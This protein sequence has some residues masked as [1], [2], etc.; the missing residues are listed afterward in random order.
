M[1]AKTEF[2]NYENIFYQKDRFESRCYTCF[3]HAHFARNCNQNFQ[4][5]RRGYAKRQYTDWKPLQVC[6][7][8]T[9]AENWWYIDSGCS[10][11]MTGDKN[12]CTK[13][14]EKNIGEVSFGDNNK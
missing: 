7:K 1:I 5:L 13:L 8:S 12:L 3:K 2:Q 4:N 11:H 10:R 9:C 6:L 14:E